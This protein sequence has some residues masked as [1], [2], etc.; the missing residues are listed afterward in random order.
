MPTVSATG[1]FERAA[2]SHCCAH[3]G[4]QMNDL[5][6][7]PFFSPSFFELISRYLSVQLEA[8]LKT[9]FINHNLK[10]VKGKN[11][12]QSECTTQFSSPQRNSFFFTLEKKK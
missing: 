12:T 6:C 5:W 1:N 3:S 7:E 11:R 8:L 9:D 10:T 2:E 4:N